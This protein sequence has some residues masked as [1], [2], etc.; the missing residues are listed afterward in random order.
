MQTT[1][2]TSSVNVSSSKLFQS[3][4]SKLTKPLTTTPSASTNPVTTAAPFSSSAVASSHPSTVTHPIVPSAITATTT[5]VAPA[6]VLKKGFGWFRKDKDAIATPAAAT[7]LKASKEKIF[8]QSAAVSTPQ[9]TKEDDITEDQENVKPFSS[10]V[11]P[12][13]APVPSVI[14]TPSSTVP[15]QSKTV[16]T[17]P[18]QTQTTQS[19]SQKQQQQQQ[20]KDQVPLTPQSESNSYEASPPNP[21]PPQPQYQI[22]DREESDASDTDGENDE[23]SVPDWAK[24]PKL[25]QALERQYGL[26]PGVPAVDPDSIF[27]E[28]QTCVLEEI[29]GRSQGKCRV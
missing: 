14:A 20:Q 13:S 29:F 4:T 3:A 16:P 2:A 18:L 22:D 19:Q 9:V 25:R 15:L 6:P 28:V 17:T 12:T 11:A 1:S 24:P 23:Q 21:S 10:A 8:T 27:P 26:I 7:S 5:H